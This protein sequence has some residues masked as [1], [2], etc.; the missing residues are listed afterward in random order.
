MCK[1]LMGHNHCCLVPHATTVLTSAA[2]RAAA[3]APVACRIK[4][5]M[6]ATRFVISSSRL[7]ACKEQH[8]LVNILVHMMVNN[9]LFRESTGHCL[10]HGP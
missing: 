1:Q 3:S 7:A 5:S 6:C 8:N 4:A 2:R 9:A 10:Q